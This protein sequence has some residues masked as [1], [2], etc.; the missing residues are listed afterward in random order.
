MKPATV[1]DGVGEA[2]GGYTVVTKGGNVLAYYI[3]NRN[4]FKEHLPKNTRYETESTSMNVYD[5]GK[6][7]SENGEDFIESNLRMRFR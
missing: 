6:V 7:Y 4:Y 2:T 5:L 1:W 3:Y